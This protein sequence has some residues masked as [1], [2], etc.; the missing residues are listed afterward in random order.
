MIVAEAQRAFGESPE[1]K[2]P[3]IGRQDVP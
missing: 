2:T 3:D 1:G